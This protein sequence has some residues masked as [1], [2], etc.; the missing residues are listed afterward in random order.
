[1]KQST[2]LLSLVL[3]LVMAFS[4]MTVV[5]NAALVKA[6]VVYD[7]LDDAALAPEQV[8]DLALDMVD[9][10]LLAGMDPVD[11]SII[12]ELRLDSIDHIFTDI[13]ELR[14]SFYW[15][16]GSGLLKNV[17]ALNFGAFN[18][19]GNNW[20]LFDT[21]K[22]YQRS[23]GDLKI[24]GQLLE[25]IGNDNNSEILSRIAY[26]MG[27]GG[28]IN[29]NGDM[30]NTAQLNLGL[31]ANF[32]DLGET[33][34]ILNDLP[35]YLV[36]MLYDMLIHGSYKAGEENDSYPA[37]EDLDA[38]P[39]EVDTLDEMVNLA[40]LNLV[41]N[42]Q[43]Y[44]WEGEGEA[45]TKVWDENSVISPSFKAYKDEMMAGGA[46]AADVAATFSP[47]SH[48]LF[49]VLDFIAQY[50][51]DDIG[52]PALNGNLKKALMEACEIDL[53]EIPRASVNAAALAEFDK[54]DY[55]T[56]VSYDSME[57]GSDG[58]W[59]YTTLKNRAVTDGNGDPVLDE[60]G[61]EVIEK[62]RIYYKANM[63]AGNEFA[64]LINWDWEFVDSKTTPTDDQVQLLYTDIVKDYDGDGTASIVE[65][66]NDLVGLVYDVALT[67]ALKADF[68]ALV[69]TGYV[70]GANSNFMTNV[71]NIAKYLLVN[72]G[73]SIFGK[74]SPYAHLEYDAIKDMDTVDLV[75]MIGPSFFEDVMPQ[76]IF[77][78][79]D[80]GTYAFHDGVQIYEF[81]ALVIRE[82]STDITPNVN[83]DAYIFE[84]GSVTSATGRQF[85]EQTADQWCNLILNMG[86]DIAYTYLY[87]ITNFGDEITLVNSDG[88]YTAGSGGVN[89]TK[90]TGMD[91]PEVNA[92]NA[93]DTSR[94]TAMLDEVIMWCVEYVGVT[95][96]TSVI[97]GFDAATIGAIDGP[98]NKLSYILNTL[99]PLG[100]VNG[101]STSSYEFDVQKFF[102]EG[103]K[104]FL[105]DFDLARVAGLFGRNTASK[106]N[107]LDDTNVVTA[108]LD[109]VND[110]LALVFRRTILQG[111][112]D[113]SAG[114]TSQSLDAVITKANLKYVVGYLLRGLYQS[115]DALLINALPVVG[116]LISGWGTEQKF[117]TPTI[118]LGNS[119]N[120]TNG[121][122]SEEQSVSIRNAS[123]GV[124]RHYVDEAG[125]EY[126]D[127]QYQILV[128]SVAAYDGMTNDA[129]TTVAVTLPTQS[130]VDYGATTAFNYTATGVPE[131]GD[132]VR[133]VVKYKVFDESGEAMANGKE[134][135]IQKYLWLNY[136]STDKGTEITNNSTL[137]YTSIY[138]PQYVP[139]SNTAEVLPTLSTGK[140]AR[141]YKFCTSSQ[142]ATL[143]NNSG[144]VDGI[145]FASLS[146]AF[147]NE[148]LKFNNLRNFDNYTAVAVD[149]DGNDT[150]NTLAVAGSV[151]A[152]AG[153]GFGK[154]SGSSTVFSISMT[155]KDGTETNN[156]TVVYYDDEMLGKLTS[157]AGNE[158]D[159]TRLVADY[160][161]TGTVYADGILT[162]AN[163]TDENGETVY[164]ES[165]F[166]TT[167]WIDSDK[168]VYS[169]SQVTDIVET[170]DDD[171][172]L[173]AATG[174]VGDVAVKKVTAID[175]EAAYNSYVAAF[176]PGVRG[177][178]QVFNANSVYDFAARYE[179]LYVAAKDFGYCK[180]TT[181]QVVA[182]GNGENIDTTVDALKTKLVNIEAATTDEKNYTDYKMWRLDRLNDARDDA[183]YYINLK[184]DASNNN[185][186]EIDESFPYTS[187]NEDDLRALVAG[188][189]TLSGYT[190]GTDNANF[191]TALLE[192]PTA[193]ELKAKTEWLENKKV[194]YGSKTLL[195]V[196]MADNA[197]ELTSARLLPKYDEVISTYL[198]D[199]LT[200]IEE[201]GVLDNEALYTAR[202]WSRFIEAYDAAC[203]IYD[204]D[205]RFTQK[206]I[207]AIKYELQCARNGLV[208][209]E[210]EAD[211]S[212]LEELIKQA[213]YALSHQSLY[214]NTAEELGKVLAELG[215]EEQIINAD[216]DVINLFPGS[217]IEVNGKAYSE[218]DQK[219]V[220]RAATALKEAL[221]KL[222][223]KGLDI[224]ATDGNAADI[225][226]DAVITPD[227]PTTTDVNEEVRATI[228]KI[229][230]EMNADAVKA[231][232]NVTA[233]GATVGT[234]NITVSNDLYYTVATDLEGFAGTN[235]VVTFY[236]VEDGV[237]F[238]VATVKIVVNGDINGDGAVDVLDGAYAQLVSTEKGELKGCY[239]I[240][241]DL[242]GDDSVVTANDY[243]AIVDIIVA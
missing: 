121:A 234:E 57:K 37:S 169:E 232:F 101:Y 186:A 32:L 195:E 86:M 222:K 200:S 175:C 111:V 11:L 148:D 95:G 131:S 216:G 36:T 4:C 19:G 29:S 163:S 49:Q 53:N 158:M 138:T 201:M 182:E 65:G 214:D 215:I 28:T 50:A 39:A 112:N 130:N 196:E 221:S 235:S 8:A 73:E 230:A 102:D 51:I 76:L 181:E 2:K 191:I 72:H 224:A 162:T 127:N 136:N 85:K 125:N 165:A 212:E 133:F 204:D 118:S 54:E 89:I 170:R 34:D 223:F 100:F 30:T 12:G 25:F 79:N 152:N 155:D 154:T 240:A 22:A 237:K 108:V 147:A 144:T 67:P 17:G 87:N 141:D 98:L 5:G 187:I 140:L 178:M 227:D 63:A 10:D 41:T 124:W 97:E 208:L 139:L 167:A 82:F 128:T 213:T 160:N 58:S 45:A 185:V 9:N 24:I 33:G 105:V 80:D 84:G 81:G 134:F 23:N 218:K 74:S 110:I 114:V 113:T 164:R 66:I 122:T 150:S 174:K 157:L 205:A 168:N 20:G 70:G 193:Q 21:K 96:T 55:V 233:T 107:A 18:T 52:V 137:L 38:L 106:Y 31:I 13:V 7:S 99:L 126:T 46:S 116:K 117:K 26:G 179:A 238:P 64:S 78:M 15:A 202:S 62:T 119:T 6:E 143:T 199:E 198:D 156:F 177:G 189:A 75:A 171:G 209:V 149:G 123:N 60:E 180:K 132:L 217:A 142:T 3:A 43:D 104:P 190:G 16:I 129:S 151:D 61:N 93:Y 135:E 56:Y 59:Y 236:T 183:R 71:C 211:Y 145:N 14:S 146:Y 172:V 188:N 219:K 44:E 159:A 83:Y 239:L 68:E 192:A 153:E 109:L 1:M 77:P 115:K 120:L 197:L 203:A 94:W 226:T 27:S 40:L 231:L 69:G 225:V 103:L 242:V 229:A 91:F 241:G 176:E 173:T 228:A 48:S 92:T 207:F 243:S 47:L 220:D 35:G 42:P 194:E 206:N 161:I 210:N 166:S 184:N 88:T 90:R